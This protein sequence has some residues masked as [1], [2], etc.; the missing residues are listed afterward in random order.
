[1]MQSCPACP[2]KDA[3]I[4]Q[5][6]V[7]LEEAIFVINRLKHQEEV[8][9]QSLDLTFKLLPVSSVGSSPAEPYPSSVE[10]LLQKIHFGVRA[11]ITE[12]ELDKERIDEL[13]VENISLEESVQLA[14]G[15]LSYLGQL[16]LANITN[17]D[18]LS[19]QMSCMLSAALECERRVA[20]LSLDCNDSGIGAVRVAAQLQLAAVSI[21]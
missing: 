1:M 17:L 4:E 9:L 11:L 3:V 8:A 13:L 6:V 14:R 15:E 20:N 10:T 21:P 18:G 12:R 2:R 19:L 5:S 16:Q 7:D